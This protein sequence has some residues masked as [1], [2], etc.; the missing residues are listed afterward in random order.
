MTVHSFSFL[1]MM[2]QRVHQLL[3][4]PLSIAM[5]Q[6]ALAT[7]FITIPVRLSDRL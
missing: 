1:V 7:G 3:L 6:L 2:Q 5:N 4:G